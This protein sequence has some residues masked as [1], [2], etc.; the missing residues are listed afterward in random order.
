VEGQ[1]ISCPFVRSVF[2]QHLYAQIGDRDVLQPALGMAG[3]QRSAPCCPLR[4]INRDI[5]NPPQ[6]R[7]VSRSRTRSRSSRKITSPRFPRLIKG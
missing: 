3:N 7:K 1:G 2:R 5:A 4:A 6:A